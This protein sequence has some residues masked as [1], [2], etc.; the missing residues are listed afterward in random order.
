MIQDRPTQMAREIDEM[1]EAARRLAEPGARSQ[2]QAVAAA[3]R[4][5]NP[6]AVA[7]VARGSSNHA[8]TYISYAIQ[9]ILGLPVAS[10]GPSLQTV[11]GMDL[12]MQG[13]AAL[14]I[15][16][17]GGS[18]DIS[19]LCRSMAKTGGHVVALTNTSE[20]PL[21]RAAQDTIDT[22]AGSE[23]AVAATKSYFNSIVAG[24]WL[25]ADWAEDHDLAEALQRLP[26]CMAEATDAGPI[27]L[28]K[29]ALLGAQK[30]T[31]ISRGPSLGLAD[32]FA[33]KLLEASDI[34]AASYSAAEVLHG[35]SAILRD[36]YPVIVL[37]TRDQKGVKQAVD[38]L[39]DQGARVI[40]LPSSHSVGH[41]LVDPLLN[42]QPLYRLAESLSVLRGLDPDNP[43]H[44]NKVT[45]TL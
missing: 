15:S 2:S 17:S 33:L 6:A 1:R 22:L 9:S 5:L 12:R 26:D 21:G 4:E 43:P 23:K 18:Q 16:Q 28:A 7:T 31:I 39:P 29:D 19:A 3:L 35:P 36:G 44:L 40:V 32:E 24:L 45:M 37:S 10:V 41:W 42:V 20:S 30:T 11:Y 8:A 38:R 13:L 25:V 14:A 34:Q 27:A